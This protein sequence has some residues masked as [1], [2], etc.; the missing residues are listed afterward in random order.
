MASREILSQLNL[1]RGTLPIAEWVN[2][3]RKQWLRPDILAGL[4]TAA[5]VIPKAMA[6]ATIAGL[7][8]QVG[9]YTAFVPLVIYAVLGT[10]CVLSVSTSTT[11]AILTAANL[12]EVVP[13]GDPAALLTATA[14]LTALVGG[15]LIIASILRLGFV[16]NF[17]SEPVLVGFKA[18]IG[19]VI[20]VDQVPKILGVHIAR[21]SFLRNVVSTIQG[22]PK[23][24]LTTLT[25]G[26]SMV[27]LLLVFERRWP[28]APAPLFAVAAGIVAAYFLNLHA[29]GVELV[30]HIP[31]GIPSVIAP[32]RSLVTRLWPGALGIALMS[33]TETVA[34]GRAFARN[35]E[36]ALRANRELLASGLANVVGAFLV[37]MPAGGGTTQT[38]VN[39]LAGS[40]TQM[41]ELVTSAMALLTMLLVAPLLGKMPQATLAAVVI[42]YSFGLIQPIEF[43][44]ILSIRRT[45]FLWALVAFA[46]VLLLGTL[47]GIVVAIIVSLVTLAYHVAD[48]PVY[49]LRRK[50]GTNVFRPQSAEHPEDEIFPA[51]LLLRLMGPIFFINAAHIAH[52]IEPLVAQAQPRVVAV[53][54]SAVL[55]LEYTALKMFVE[56]TRRERDRGVQVW[57]VGMNPQVLEVVQRSPL[58]EML[59]RHGMHFNL[60]I[61]V[62]R[63]LSAQGTAPL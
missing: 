48:P 53:D 42:V 20:V 6:Y 52:K 31:K 61:A 27:A 22:L 36:P 7:P 8:V 23:T 26:L 21:G 17:I 47:K 43:R 24:S 58:G 46:G 28:K 32:D 51:L 29:H 33:F 41:A 38:A 60:E 39:R 18:G 44:D 63:Y 34:T 35:D 45:E 50:P 25:L 10:S 49:V 9:L 4:T 5:V 1:Q 40:R 2:G 19:V 59:G 37:A 15:I 62:A 3:Y 56:A 13:S 30:G 55:D 54:L 16:A 11:L 57:L 12:A 14:T